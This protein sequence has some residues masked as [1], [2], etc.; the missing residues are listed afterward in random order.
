[1]PLTGLA[2]GRDDPAL[3]A[4]CGVGGYEWWPAEDRLVCS[5]GLVRIYGLGRAPT[6]EEAFS[7]LVHPEDRVRVAAETAAYLGS[8]AES[9][10]HNFRIVR[11]DGSIRLVLDRGS[12]ERDEDGV[13]RFVRGLNIDLTEEP[14]AANITAAR[15]T[16]EQ[17][18]AEAALVASEWRFKGVYEHS[19]AGMVVCDRHGRILRCNPAFCRLVGYPEEELRGRHFKE[20]IHPEDRN[21]DQAAVR[22]VGR[23]DAA[24]REME[25]RYIHSRGH[26][27]WAQKIV[28][29]LPDGDGRLLYFALVI[30]IDERKK[31][32]EALRESE[33]RLQA[34]LEG[35]LDPIFMKDR[36]GRMVL[37]NPATCAAAGKPPEAILGKTDEQ[38]LDNPADARAIMAND[39]RIM[40]S[41]EPETVE[42]TVTTP[43]GSRYYV[44]KKA[45]RRDAAGNIIG[46][47]STAR[48]VT[49]QKQTEAA[50]RKREALLRSA[51]D[52]AGVGLVMLNR[53]RRYVYAN[54]PYSSILGLGDG[55]IVGKGPAEVLA[56]VYK[57]QISPRLDRAFA[58]ERVS[59]ELDRPDAAGTRY[60]TVVYE[61]LRD[62]DGQIANVIVVIYDITEPKLA[63]IRIAESEARE[64]E[65]RQE[66][67]TLLSAI[68]A[69]VLIAEDKACSRMTANRQCY[70]LMRIPEGANVS[71]TANETE[72]PPHLEVY[73]ASGEMLAP[74]QLPMQLAAATGISVEGFEYELR[75]AD[76]SH[77]HHL[78]NALPLFD[79][80]GEVRGAVGAFLD[81]TERR[82]Q[83]ERIKLLL[84]EVNHRTKNMLAVI[85]SVARQTVATSPKNFLARFS[86]R[87]QSLATSQDLLVKADWRG[88]D[89]GELVRGQ[90]AHFED[91]IG[92]RIELKG[93]S[94]VISASAAQTFGMAIHE[95]STNAGKYGA[96][97][98]DQGHVAIDWLLE[99]DATGGETF[100]MS[101][102]EH[103]GPP[104]SPPSRN[105]FGSRVIG[106]LAESSLDAKV[107]LDFAKTGLSWRLSC[108]AGAVIEGA[109][110]ALVAEAR[111]EINTPSS[112]RPKVLVVEDE[113]LVA[114]E[115]AHVL[116]T[117]GFEVVGPV[118]TSAQA[119][120]LVEKIGCDA[121]VLDINLGGG[122]TSEPVALELLARGA[123]FITLSG[124]S[125]AQHLPIFDGVPALSKPLR[126]TLL[127]DEIKRC[128]ASKEIQLPDCSPGIPSG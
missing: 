102:R 76:G 81:I 105:G 85:Q 16:A 15:D 34:V 18:R 42:E 86:E 24:F 44:N 13:V 73:S 8:N 27:V 32:E 100:T 22:D 14:A 66:L 31:A 80:A 20:L 1:M 99:R 71:M 25:S 111:G 92:S 11:P 114:M 97:S 26:P 78:G 39:Q 3:E 49:E 112:S 46:L 95:L 68:P 21:R 116:K 120:S 77:R 30:G 82:H 19:I 52:N 6:A 74:S 117:A 55:N 54:R 9:F 17:K 51:T 72:R 121:A 67:E 59:Y 43:S 53:D 93:P 35:S 126:P 50:L 28:S 61:P 62:D 65:R 107:A 106:A 124:Y 98:V 84:R 70:E 10:S 38:F 41:G 109:R 40:S 7:R 4:S 87:I 89:V 37:A 12:I 118:G 119:L 83:E 29:A 123:R 23:G 101:W 110:P 47:I 91:L 125:R 60:Y 57:D 48:E 63:A 96:L 122:K 56:G 2:T 58:G 69:I 108:P 104:V 90:L 45:P 33:A 128:L 75:F 113:A 88:V 103:G 79:A 115:I 5:S 64:R 36:E 94:L 127:I